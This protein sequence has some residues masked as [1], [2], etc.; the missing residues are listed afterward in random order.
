MLTG[1]N[2]FK[3]L[4]SSFFFFTSHFH[5]T[6]YAFCLMREA[7]RGSKLREKNGIFMCL[8]NPKLDLP[9]S[10]FIP[11]PSCRVQRREVK[12]GEESLLDT[13]PNG[14]E[15]QKSNCTRSELEGTFRTSKSLHLFSFPGRETQAQRGK[16]TDTMSHSNVVA[17]LGQ[18]P[19]L[20][21][22]ILELSTQHIRGQHSSPLGQ[23][24]AGR[25]DLGIM[26]CPQ[27]TELYSCRV[28]KLGT[29]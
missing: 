25:E 29:L 12:F 23:G 9:S 8:V 22:P 20:L 2:S 26:D 14:R 24:G 17:E 7:L 16:E 18:N 19:L 6:F 1:L 13:K 27:F 21:I 3:E 15:T 4:R 10:R 11:K 5:K 28:V